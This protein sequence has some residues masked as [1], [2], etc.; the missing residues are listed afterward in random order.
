MARL[1][2]KHERANEQ[3]G[4]AFAEIFGNLDATRELRDQVDLLLGGRSGS[5]SR[6]GVDSVELLVMMLRDEA[7]GKRERLSLA[8][9]DAQDS[10]GFDMR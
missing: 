2:R 9:A 3:R 8:L 4:I 1:L 6:G 5:P 7:V 10:L